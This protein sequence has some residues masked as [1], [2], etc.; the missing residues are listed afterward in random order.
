MFKHLGVGFLFSLL[1]LMSSIQ[2]SHCKYCQYSKQG[3]AKALI[4]SLNPDYQKQENECLYFERDES[5]C[6][7]YYNFYRDL[8]DST[9]TGFPAYLPWFGSL[10]KRQHV[11]IKDS[12]FKVTVLLGL[13]IAPLIYIGFTTSAFSTNK[14][15]NTALLI[16]G[17]GI[18]LVLIIKSIVVALKGSP[19]MQLAPEGIQINN[20]AYQWKNF[21]GR[22][23]EKEYIGIPGWFNRPTVYVSLFFIGSDKPFRI[24]ITFQNYSAYTIVQFIDSFYKRYNQNVPK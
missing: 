16:I 23:I 20:Q 1:P 17:F 3:D 9:G 5:R 8:S 4:C 21:V 7:Y 19:N 12:W 6:K 18:E 15:I 14:L 2:L 11:V 22:Q 10:M 24:N 13:I